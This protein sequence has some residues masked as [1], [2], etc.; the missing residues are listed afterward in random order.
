MDDNLFPTAPRGNIDTV[1][2]A[3]EE[4]NCIAWAVWNTRRVIWPDEYGQY[5]WPPSIPRAETVEAMRQF[6]ILAGFVD[7]SIANFE[8]GIEKNRDLFEKW[9]ANA[10]CAS[11]FF[12]SVDQ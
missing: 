3:T 6:F 5:A 9:C 1:S 10:R 11:T 2:S 8:V 7:C 4:Y 12:R